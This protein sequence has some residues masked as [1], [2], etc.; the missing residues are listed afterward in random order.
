ML[1]CVTSKGVGLR[2]E[3]SPAEYTPSYFSVKHWSAEGANSF[4]L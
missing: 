3:L 2:G 4:Q 1:K